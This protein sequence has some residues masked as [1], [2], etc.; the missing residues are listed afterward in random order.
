ML[1]VYSQGHYPLKCPSG[2]SS[3]RFL[4][5]ISLIDFGLRR[6]LGRLHGFD[7]V[8]SSWLLLFLVSVFLCCVVLSGE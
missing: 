4:G 6:V 3:N 7:F 5:V 1:S 2:L 8:V